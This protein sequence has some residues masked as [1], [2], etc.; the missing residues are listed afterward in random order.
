METLPAK[1]LFEPSIAKGWV[2]DG[3]LSSLAK[4][5]KNSSEIAKE[6]GV[7]KATVS[8]HTKSLVRKGMIEISDVETVRG[9]VYSKTFSLRPRPMILVRRSMGREDART[10]ID[11]IFERMLMSWHIKPEREP[12]DEVK[13]FLYHLFRLFA[14]EGTWDSSVFEEFG[15]RVGSELLSTSPRFSTLKG[16][17]RE[18]AEYLGERRMA[19][20]RVESGKQEAKVV[21][22]SCFENSDHGS[23]VCDFTKGVIEGSLRARRGAKYSVEREGTVSDMACVFTVKRG[24]AKQ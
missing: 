19:D 13:V 17:T 5:P 3:I 20:M 7:S 15:A 24:R 18:L 22:S 2:R 21:C 6:L 14:E 23:L 4:G 9:G 12:A 16:G 8:Y 1:A 10:K 11:D